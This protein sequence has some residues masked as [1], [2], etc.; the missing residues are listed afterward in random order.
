MPS[1]VSFSESE[2]LQLNPKRFSRACGAE[3]DTEREEKQ[4]KI[5]WE[6]IL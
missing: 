2:D 3:N 5:T 4:G 6:T 1:S